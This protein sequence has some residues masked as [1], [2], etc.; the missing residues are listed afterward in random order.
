[1]GLVLEAVQP[2]PRDRDGF[3]VMRSFADHE[4]RRAVPL[5]RLVG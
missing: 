5:R 2:N 3:F 1:M 4:L